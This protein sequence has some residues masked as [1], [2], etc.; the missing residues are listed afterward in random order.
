MRKKLYRKAIAIFGIAFAVIMATT[1][2]VGCP[3][4]NG[5]ITEVPS[6]S[7]PAVVFT[8]APTSLELAVNETRPLQLTVQNITGQPQWSS[9][10]TAVAT[11]SQ[12]P[13]NQ[14]LV[15]GVSEGEATITASLGLHMSSA[16]IIVTPD[17]TVFEVSVEH[18]L[19]F[20]GQALPG[21]IEVNTTLSPL[22]FR[23]DN[24][25][26][27]T[28]TQSNN[29][30]FVTPVAPGTTNIIITAGGVE[31]AVS[32]AVSQPT[33]SI[34]QDFLFL[35]PNEEFQLTGV[36][37]PENQT[38][39]WAVASGQ[40]VVSVNNAGLVTA[41]AYGNAIVSAN[42]GATSDSV[43]IM[44]ADEFIAI[45][46]TPGSM[47]L[48]F[49]EQRAFTASM[50]L[51]NEE[52]PD[53]VAILAEELEVVWSSANTSIATVNQNGLVTAAENA[54]STIVRASVTRGE[55]IFFAEATVN[56]EEGDFILVSTADEL[57]VAMGGPIT[58]RYHT[59]SPNPFVN[60]S[61]ANDIDMGGVNISTLAPIASPA[62]WFGWEMPFMGTLE[63][64][65]F[66]IY[67]FTA[68][69][70]MRG[71]GVTG[72]IRNITIE[73]T[74]T[75][76]GTYN[77][78]GGAGI[79]PPFG[80]TIENSVFDI[81]YT[82][83]TA[84][85]AAVATVGA[86]MA[87][88]TD[89]IF[90]MRG[91]APTFNTTGNALFTGSV[92]GVFENVFVA[93]AGRPTNELEGVTV[94]GLNELTNVSI[95]ENRLNPGAWHLIDGFMPRLR[96]AYDHFVTTTIAPPVNDGMEL[97]DIIQLS[98]VTS[99]PA[100]RQNPIVWISSDPTRA[101]VDA[102][103]RVRAS[104]DNH[105]T[106]T[107]S[108]RSIRGILVDTIDIEILPRV[109]VEAVPILEPNSTYT[110][111]LRYPRGYIRFIS[112]NPNIVSVDEYTGELTAN[113]P[114]AV[115]T[116]FVTSTLNPNFVVNVNVRVAETIVLSVP[117]NELSI[118]PS[119][120]ITLAP[121]INRGNLV[122]TIIEGAALATMTTTDIS[123]T[124]AI[125]AGAI[126][127][128][129]VRVQSAINLDIYEYITL[130]IDAVAPIALY[131]S[132]S[133]AT[134]DYID[135]LVLGVTV[136]N[137]T[138]T[139]TFISTDT[140]V[141]TVDANGVI[142]AVGT[143]TTTITVTLIDGTTT[144]TRTVAITV[145]LLPV[146]VVILDGDFMFRIGQVRTP[147][148]RV[149]RGD[150]IW[151]SYD[152]EIAIVDNTGRITAVA[153]GLVRI[154]LRSAHAPDTYFYFIYVT[155]LYVTVTNLD[156]S[157]L[158]DGLR[159]RTNFALIYRVYPYDAELIWTSSN[160][161]IVAVV[162]GTLFAR[163]PGTVII[164]VRLAMD[165]LV[166]FYF[167]LTAVYNPDVLSFTTGQVSN[168]FVDS[169]AGDWVAFSQMGA[170]LFGNFFGTL[171][172]NATGTAVIGGH[173]GRAVNPTLDQFVVDH[174]IVRFYSRPFILGD[175]AFGESQ[176][177]NT[178]R[179]YWIWNRY[180]NGNI[181]RHGEG[182][183]DA[184]ER[185]IGWLI[186]IP[187]PATLSY[188]LNTDGLG[189]ISHNGV[190]IYGGVNGLRFDNA[191]QAGAFMTGDGGFNMAG[192]TLA[193]SP[194][195]YNL[196]YITGQ[197]IS[198]PD[199]NVRNGP[200]GPLFRRTA[201]M[202]FGGAIHPFIA[203]ENTLISNANAIAGDLANIG[204][205]N[206]SLDIILAAEASA[207]VVIGN[208]HAIIVPR[209]QELIERIEA[210]RALFNQLE[211]NVVSEFVA[212]VNALPLATAFATMAQQQVREYLNIVSEMRRVFDTTEEV[213]LARTRDRI[214]SG[215]LAN[216]LD[217][218]ERLEEI[219]DAIN[220]ILPANEI[221]FI[222]AVEAISGAITFEW[223][224]FGAGGAI[225]DSWHLIQVA[226]DAYVAIGTPTA[227][228]ASEVEDAN[229]ML[230]GVRTG[231]G[232]GGF[233]GEYLRL[234]E[235]RR[236]VA[237]RLALPPTRNGAPTG[238]G[239]HT[240]SGSVL[241]H[242]SAYVGGGNWEAMR[243][244]VT[245][246]LLTNMALTGGALTPFNLAQGHGDWSDRA[247]HIKGVQ[248]FIFPENHRSTVTG[249]ARWVLHNDLNLDGTPVGHLG[250]F[251]VVSGLKY[252]WT[253]NL[254]A[255][256]SD[257]FTNPNYP[258]VGGLA[259]Y[260]MDRRHSLG[261]GHGNA[262]GTWGTAINFR[263]IFTHAMLNHFDGNEAYAR[264]F[265][266][267]VIGRTGAGF[268]TE[269]GFLA[270][271]GHFRTA[272]RFIAADVVT[273]IRDENNN[274]I[275]YE[276]FATRFV[277]SLVSGLS[278]SD[279]VQLGVLSAFR[280][281]HE[282]GTL[283]EGNANRTTALTRN[284]GRIARIQWLA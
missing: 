262:H 83:S 113:M 95:F 29:L 237:N 164:T 198:R 17:D 126:G 80:G 94:I 77:A 205:N 9:S 242:P 244:D 6:P 44:V 11:I 124:V 190:L 71:L 81:T 110:I 22:S 199:A 197:L 47:A 123:A 276:F 227:S 212:S 223:P 184:D 135:V 166:Y 279:D 12:M 32:V 178:Q 143:G 33:V 111:S 85:R 245:G 206:Q 280:G 138:E 96:N 148:I 228:I 137:S 169:G 270:D 130:N 173:F 181:R 79:S 269:I 52:H 247:N 98:A 120:S 226:L 35:R 170:G 216:G 261:G 229:Y 263:R 275:R 257:F 34:D 105:G 204:Y 201:S 219:W 141:A 21:Q 177:V 128:V 211:L 108:A 99:E 38:V 136:V 249:S 250:Y 74:S 55:N 192:A 25:S 182:T 146:E 103:G 152:P 19:L 187:Y 195:Q 49:G 274:I 20:V 267:G 59:D 165:A 235:A 61:L 221:A 1:L 144:L 112:D 68:R 57:M 37:E 40:G 278:F 145:E 147:D 4:D 283:V 268:A 133:E 118:R 230:Q 78:F 131:L 266:P 39:T 154:Y 66:T 272:G 222:T 109:V 175:L 23:T 158:V 51:Y 30:A 232:L 196:R 155:A 252:G 188:T 160:S 70:L 142:V 41:L 46:L 231:V 88:I 159:E 246:N 161:D 217:A 27:A 89:S 153:G 174:V 91:S 258:V 5:T 271:S 53:G 172:Y 97:G 64:N 282:A 218:R 28:V 167:E 107:I 24:S 233:V 100:N 156:A 48:T 26:I 251:W 121:S 171:R 43:S 241:F 15:R 253:D 102:L 2:F 185:G 162:N 31:R 264:A 90:I 209:N 151:E 189:T 115:T 86:P 281:Y 117:Q 213:V 239:A 72:V 7:S 14:V 157:E 259:G 240:H 224:G 82:T 62:F 214:L 36:F 260:P 220:A 191:A 236:T 134:L 13:N 114:D 180:P 238:G 106:V 225:N 69:E 10:D 139:V 101:I 56:V 122:F 8:I 58:G 163:V 176:L 45:E 208:N 93:S 76:G 256:N 119:T 186:R 210:A 150:W 202:N 73:M 215:A 67:N 42:I 132:H 140:S 104:L 200:E 179:F 248:I 50:R 183:S 255:V 129:V 265:F 203:N 207:T 18:L 84:S 277:D 16:V 125:N 284:M 194:L 168:V 254:Y 243:G 234:H 65:G 3:S 54:G 193:S 116:I 149:N 63:G 273:P 60:V 127:Q 92:G 87:R 75:A